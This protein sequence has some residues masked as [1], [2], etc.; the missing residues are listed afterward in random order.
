ME[1]TLQKKINFVNALSMMSPKALE[2]LPLVK[3]YSD[4]TKND[5][6]RKQIHENDIHH[7]FVNFLMSLKASNQTDLINT[8]FSNISINS[9]FYWLFNKAGQYSQVAF[10]GKTVKELYE[11]VSNINDGA[12]TDVIVRRW[13][14]NVNAFVRNVFHENK[15]SV[16]IETELDKLVKD[17]QPSEYNR[18]N[19]GRLLH[20]GNK[21][22]INNLNVENCYGL[23][24]NKENCDEAKLVK[25]LL[26]GDKQ[27][28]EHIKNINYDLF[29][30][31]FDTVKEMDPLSAKLVLKSL[32]IHI[33]KKHNAS[34]NREI[35]EPESF[36]AWE[37][38]L[39]KAQQA[40][41]KG[42]SNL[43]AYMKG[44]ILFLQQ[45][46]AML[47]EDINA[48]TKADVDVN[49]YAELKLQMYD[50]P[51]KNTKDAILLGA[52]LLRENLIF[53]PVNLKLQMPYAMAFA[54]QFDSRVAQVGGGDLPCIAQSAVLRRM[55]AIAYDNLNKN[56]KQLAQ[57]DVDAI[58]N[59]IKQVEA[60][61]EQM[62][63]I[64]GWMQ[65][66]NALANAFKEN[67]AELL[68]GQSVVDVDAM[69][70]HSE[71]QK[72]EEVIN[73]LQ[74][75]AKNNVEK[76]NSMIRNLMS[77]IFP[78]LIDTA[79]SRPNMLVV[80]A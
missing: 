42:F 27:F 26:A 52:D 6:Q 2:N 9:P 10:N 16:K 71:P 50:P 24:L 12:F 30:A 7:E 31:G 77:S 28:F 58:E 72:L 18:D 59:A 55:F 79:F 15:E 47:N 61:E 46:P 14:L 49:S 73:K 76:T 48:G 17:S 65:K 74:Q 8:I 22:D 34:L 23:G 39:D 32:D 53:A 35:N 57:K 38:R 60:R 70:Q 1:V 51:H 80:K 75:I 41:V 20:N 63:K 56:G 36:E 44:V 40:K 67:G 19:K 25:Y 69:R 4:F 13:N 29:K 11:I 64:L 62:V 54:R 45:N 78:A 37:S 68:E 66:F 3:N 5:K 33:V 21:V 43:V